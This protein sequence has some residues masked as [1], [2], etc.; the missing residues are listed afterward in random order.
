MGKGRVLVE[1][2]VADGRGR[3]LGSGVND[4]L[5][6][7][8]SLPSLSMCKR[9]FH[10]LLRVRPSSLFIGSSQLCAKHFPYL[11]PTT[12]ILGITSTLYA[13]EDGTDRKFRNVGTKSSDAG[14]LPKKH[15]TEVK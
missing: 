1:K 11:Y 8:G 10:D 14:R 3:F 9:G 5:V 7:D 6:S 4:H 13:Y 2:Q 12:Q 15:S